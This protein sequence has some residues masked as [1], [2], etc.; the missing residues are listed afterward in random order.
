M[1]CWQTSNNNTGEQPMT[2][3]TKPISPLRQR[4]IE[5]MTMRK[6]SPR[7]QSTTIR[8]VANFT[9][10]LTRSPDTA[11]AENLRRYQFAPGGPRSVGDFHQRQ[12]Y[13]SET[14]L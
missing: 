4:M 14:V 5:D 10:F 13:R 8:V 9:R 3:S 6:L 1:L 2:Q 12:H 7:T 11:E